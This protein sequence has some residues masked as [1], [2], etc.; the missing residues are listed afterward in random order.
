MLREGFRSDEGLFKSF[1]SHLFKN[2]TGFL[3]NVSYSCRSRIQLFGF[4]FCFYF[5][6]GIR[7]S[8]LEF[9]SW[10]WFWYLRFSMALWPLFPRS[11]FRVVE[12]VGVCLFLGLSRRV[13]RVYVFCFCRVCLLL[14]FF[15]ECP[16]RVSVFVIGF[17]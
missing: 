3:Q 14:F 1:S 11:V 6:F 17:K 13:F 9:L 7:V 5:F 15:F 2:P 16:L 12:F 10:S 8:T 4:F